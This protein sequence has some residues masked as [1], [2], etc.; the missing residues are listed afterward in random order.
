MTASLR[1]VTLIFFIASQVPT[2]L[3]HGASTTVYQDA[4]REVG[5]VGIALNESNFQ[6]RP[7]RGVTTLMALGFSDQNQRV[8]VQRAVDAV[9]SRYRDRPVTLESRDCPFATQ[10]W[11]VLVRPGK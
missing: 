3:E 1:V 9:S 6:N 7:K 5:L 4:L 2:I 8:G 11:T 10:R